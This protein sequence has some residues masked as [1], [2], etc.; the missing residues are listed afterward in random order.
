MSISSAKGMLVR[1]KKLERSHGAT[2]E[3]RGWVADSFGAAIA[4]GRMC[5]VD[6]RVVRDCLLK[7]LSDGTARSGFAGEGLLR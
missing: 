4:D 2:D 1:L 6:G 3:M 5:P 7:W